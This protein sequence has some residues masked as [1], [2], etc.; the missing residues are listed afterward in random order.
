MHAETSISARYDHAVSLQWQLSRGN[1]VFDYGLL[2]DL[3]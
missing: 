1:F 3:D 2:T